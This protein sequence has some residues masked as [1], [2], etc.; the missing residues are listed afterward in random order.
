MIPLWGLTKG[1]TRHI[2]CLIKASRDVYPLS[3]PCHCLR[4]SCKYSHSICIA[5]FDFLSCHSR[6]TILICW[7]FK[8]SFN[9]CQESCWLGILQ[10][11]A[12]KNKPLLIKCLWRWPAW[13][14]LIPAESY[15]L[16]YEGGV[17]ETSQ[18]VWNDSP[19]NGSSHVSVVHGL[20]ICRAG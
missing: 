14:G 13:V 6:R 4:V 9:P 20:E 7:S 12:G 18:L 19:H 17:T 2:L 1:P 16:R 15:D 8:W 11:P 3:F 5:I 10:V